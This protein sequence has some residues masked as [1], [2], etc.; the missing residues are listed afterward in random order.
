MDA[1]PN[2]KRGG[3]KLMW[4]ERKERRRERTLAKAERL[5]HQHPIEAS[6][7]IYQQATHSAHLKGGPFLP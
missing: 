5:S 6:P 1:E 4:R 3:F 7:E 2:T